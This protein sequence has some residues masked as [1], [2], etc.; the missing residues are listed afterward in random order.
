MN[1]IIKMT[2]IAI[3]MSI[4]MNPILS[5]AD[6]YVISANKSPMAGAKT[7]LCEFPFGQNGNFEVKYDYRGWDPDYIPGQYP[8]GG[9]KFELWLGT[10]AT[11]QQRDGLTDNIR[12]VIFYNNDTGE[13]FELSQADKYLYVDDPS[14]EYGIWLGNNN[15]VL[16]RWDIIVDMG[17]KK[18]SASYTLTQVMLDKDRPLPVDPFVAFNGSNFTVSALITNGDVYRFRVFDDNG[19]IVVNEDMS[20]N[21]NIASVVVP[22]QYAGYSTRIE[23]RFN[24]GGDW[25]ALMAWGT[26]GTCNSNGCVI[27]AGSARAS[28]NFRIEESQ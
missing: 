13:Y 27:G 16:G 15:R 7:S 8:N 17:S 20:I 14:G 25:V 11:V 3:T 6:F 2:I 23:T 28:M 22:S 10:F 21:S 4:V 26:P 12:K 5:I 19:N 18:Y 24:S 9:I 1:R